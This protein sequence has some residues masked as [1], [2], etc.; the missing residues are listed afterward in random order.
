MEDIATDRGYR[1]LDRPIAR[2]QFVRSF[3]KNEQG[4]IQTDEH[5]P[6]S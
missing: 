6:V 1:S 3:V 5:L 4:A 2:I